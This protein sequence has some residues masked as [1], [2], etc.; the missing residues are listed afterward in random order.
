VWNPV[1][2]FPEAHISICREILPAFCGSMDDQD[3]FILGKISFTNS[4]SYWILHNLWA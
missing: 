2:K 3:E 4:K 1:T